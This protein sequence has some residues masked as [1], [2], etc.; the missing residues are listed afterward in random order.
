MVAP[1]TDCFDVSTMFPM[2]RRAVAIAA[3]AAVSIQAGCSSSKTAMVRAPNLYADSSADPYANVPADL[4]STTATVLYATDR[5][6]ETVEGVYGYGFTRSRGVTYGLCDVRMGTEATTWAELVTASSTHE[7]DEPIPLTLTGIDER[8]RYPNLGPMVLIDDEWVESPEEVAA[9]DRNREA[10]QKMLSERL[11]MTPRKEVFLFVHGYN[12]SFES[13]AFRTAQIWHFIGRGGIPVLFS[14]PA[15]S[16]GLLQG[17]T[18]DRES[19]EFANPHLKRIL[20]DMASCPDV[21]KINLI[22]H[23]RGTDVLGTAMRELNNEAKAAGKNPRKELKIG[24]FVLAA[25]DIDLQVFIER[26]GNDRV[27]FVADQVTIY[28]SPNDKAIGLSSWLFGSVRRMGQAGFSDM[29]ADVATAIK[30][31]STMSIVD[32][33]GK[34]DRT[35]HGYFLSSPAALSDLILVLRDGRKPG[36]ANGRPLYDDPKGFWQLRDGYPSQGE[37]VADATSVK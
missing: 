31:H 16:T 20:R 34:T 18:R 11:A 5:E 13:G 15:G 1:P 4:Q 17:Y 8:G 19:G 23:S 22:C 9:N 2:M 32:M 33:R 35:G 36:A 28:A 12:N 6:P 29:D 24:Q 37:T 25:P 30:H 10:L 7:R 3:L 27:G 21:Q 14:W 26:F